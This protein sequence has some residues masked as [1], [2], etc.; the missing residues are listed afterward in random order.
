[1]ANAITKRTIKLA[2][3]ARE[4][5]VSHGTASNVF[6][7][8]D[9][10]RKEVQARVHAA[11]AKLGY[12]GPSPLG[13]ML[14]AGKVNAI[15]VATAEPLSYFFEDPF[16]R[17]VMQGVSEACDR[18]GAG[19]A[20]VSSANS[21]HLAWNMNSAV[22]DGFV[23]FCLE[24]GSKLI[25]LARDRQLPFVALDYGTDDPDVATFG[26]DDRHGAQ[27]AAR[28]LTG[29]GHRRFGVLSLQSSDTPNGP[30][31]F[32][33]I[34]NCAYSG[35]RDRILGYFDALAEAGID[36][37]GT[38]IFET[39]NDWETTSAGLE[40][41][42]ARDPGITALLC[43]SDRMAIYAFDWFAARGMRVPQDV[44]VVG[45]DGVPE[46]ERSIPPL[47]TVVQPIQELGRRAA[48]TILDGKAISIEL[49]VTLAIRG[50]T[51]P[52]PNRA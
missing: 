30:S 3:V 7:R 4:A 43:M 22:V 27:L 36:R 37:S 41:L 13:R 14:R 50:S 44:S 49:P 38:P 17:V 15:G 16:S 20:L 12:A 46:A 24:G 9:V 32:E 28:H 18:R 31:S 1:M 40:Y 34:S 39:D 29:L 25:E 42:F 26:I 33:R 6:S 23:V 21:E 48:E 19:I 2:D 8:P 52:P 5:G 35:T 51:A 10:V 11:A 45:F 47:T